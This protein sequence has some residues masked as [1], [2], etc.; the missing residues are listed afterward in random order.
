MHY[1]QCDSTNPLYDRLE[2]PKKRRE[3]FPSAK[4][5]VID[6]VEGIVVFVKDAKTKG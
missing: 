5:A 6:T 3:S 1:L 2:E 4:F